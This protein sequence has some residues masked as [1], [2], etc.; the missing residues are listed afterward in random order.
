MVPSAQRRAN[1]LSSKTGTMRPEYPICLTGTALTAVLMINA[2][3][4]VPLDPNFEPVYVSIAA[5]IETLATGAGVGSTPMKL[6]RVAAATCRRIVSAT[7]AWA[8][9]CF[10]SSATEASIVPCVRAKIS[11][12]T[13]APS[14]INVVQDLGSSTSRGSSSQ[15]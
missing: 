7:L 2:A 5:P 13:L 6:Q 8:V 11:C 12:T 3:V 14:N 15:Y 9:N 4:M 10:V 1:T